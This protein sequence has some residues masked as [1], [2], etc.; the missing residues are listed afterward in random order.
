MRSAKSIQFIYVKLTMNPFCHFEFNS[1]SPDLHHILP[2][3][4]LKMKKFQIHPPNFIL[5]NVHDSIGQIKPFSLQNSHLSLLFFLHIVHH[6]LVVCIIIV[7]HPV[8][9]FCFV[10]FYCLLKTYINRKRFE[11]LNFK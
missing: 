1:I 7:I 3:L 5:T 10:L 2:P 8:Y 6:Q 11:I 4:P 9:M